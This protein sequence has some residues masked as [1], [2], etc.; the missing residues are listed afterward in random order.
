MKKHAT[1]H[2]L[3]EQY[4]LSVQS[5]IKFLNR[6][7]RNIKGNTVLSKKLI[8]LVKG[9]IT[10]IKDSE[11]DSEDIDVYVPIKPSDEKEAIFLLDD[12]SDDRIDRIKG[13]STDIT[14]QVATI[15]F[16]L[17]RVLA[18]AKEFNVGQDTLIDYLISKGFDR[19]DLKPTAK[20]SAEMYE[21]LL[22]EFSS[23][24]AAKIKSDQ[25][26]LPMESFFPNNRKKEDEDIGFRKLNK[27]ALHLLEKC[28]QRKE[29]YLD[30]GNCGLTDE[31]FEENT[32]LYELLEKCQ[33]LEILVLSNE[34]FEIQDGVNILRKSSNSGRRNFINYIPYVINKLRGL[35]R[36][37]LSGDSNQSGICIQSIA[38]LSSLENLKYLNLSN[39]QI[40]QIHQVSTF[41]KLTHLDLSKNSIYLIE[42]LENLRDVSHLNL[43]G[44]LLSIIS[45]LKNM[46]NLKH[47]DLS[48]N[49][50][51]KIEDLD[52]LHALELLD[53][54]ANEIQVIEGIENLN[55]LKYLLL[56]DNKISE[57]Q[58]LE[59][60]IDREMEI[61]I[62][63][64]ENPVLNRYRLKVERDENHFPFLKELLIRQLD[65]SQK[66][67]FTYPMKILVLGNHASGKSSLVN[68]L[69]NSESSGSTH[70]LRIENYFIAKR[71]SK[72]SIPD[73]VFYDFGG[74]DFYHG[75]YQAFISQGSLQ[76]ILFDK[77]TDKN[78][79]SQD[80]S[81]IPI[82][83]FDRKY[84]LGQK[85]YQENDVD[86]YDPYIMVQ[87]Y[88]DDS[89]NL[90]E[91]SDYAKYP[92]FKN[93]FF[94]SFVCQDLDHFEKAYFDKGKEYF[95]AYFNSLLS[96]Y[97]NATEEPRWYIEF[98][99]FIL[100][101]QEKA[102]APIVLSE[103]LKHYN[104]KDLS[105]DDRLESLK[106]NLVTLHRHGLVLYYPKIHELV[107]YVW[108]N[109]EELVKHIQ[110]E[111]LS[112]A[113]AG[114][115][116]NANS[117]IIPRKD[118]E[119]IVQDDKT[120]LL[121]KEQK[122][123][124]LHKPNNDQANDEYI[125]PNYLKLID[126]QN[127]EF[128]LFMF[129]I[130]EPGLF[131]KF[132][133]FIPFG[134]INQMICFFGK[135]PDVKKFWRTQLVFTLQHN[136]RV[137]IEIDF[138]EL[139]IKV[140]YQSAGESSHDQNLLLEYLFYSIMGLYWD[141]SDSQIPNFG[142]FL[143]IKEAKEDASLGVLSEKLKK[144]KQLQIDPYYIPRDLYLSLNGKKF[145]S[146]IELFQLSDEVYKINGYGLLDGRVNLQDSLQLSI[147]DFA[148]FTQR[149]FFKMKKIF[150]SYSKHD[151]DYLQDFEDHLV[152]L[153]QEGVATFNCRDI[154]FG[155]EWDEEIKKQIDECDIM[156]CLVSVKF[157]NT[158]YITRI[159]IKKAIEQN[160]IIVPIIIKACDWESSVLGKYQAAQRGRIV[161]LDNYKRLA[162]EIKSHTAEER[163]AFWT[164][165]IKEF[166]TKLLLP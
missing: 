117:G 32:L 62:Q 13:S 69:I 105:E 64:A 125:I 140:H 126:R 165:I 119:K 83:N 23:D 166:R 150:I 143:Q 21:A 142:E 24:K 127:K 132:N 20:L 67:T 45:G 17:P 14:F 34:W 146:Y 22:S 148:P 155:K 79:I 160:K 94:L 100:N 80:V 11:I 18:A 156:I 26:E 55:K 114:A 1:P 8:G 109:P 97:R 151:E 25:L 153:K 131:I 16:K 152:T 60:L 92:G 19:N 6:S 128:Q 158:D 144:W 40:S 63:I 137:L 102:F 57:I 149:K 48:Y 43:S 163:A 147:G 124:F 133:D 53:I 90:P 136:I 15:P 87:S 85:A 93:S 4:N 74:Q 103:V 82:I 99:K 56:N 135:E 68:Y 28:I 106:T 3:A 86:N 91:Y 141:L 7:G 2:S 118:F 81:G 98:L 36:L 134:F 52:N 51:T 164:S 39:N 27:S 154:E 88:A 66:S 116:G 77:Q 54:S 10:T 139:M 129:G 161:S 112:V 44:N 138:E 108:L 107:D 123:V 70:I 41:E 50:I 5:I 157:L 72:S 65:S 104:A 130:S 159:E 33:H 35:T 46:T 47:L 30:L 58:G 120:L 162:G 84:W 31:D 71:G 12:R 38:P 76:I 49:T 101:K 73:A 110:T 59:F 37:V 113:S 145:V 75:L 111:I 29:S 96:K 95:K 122:V 61:V 121:L 115:K 89:K 78:K 42:G 9:N